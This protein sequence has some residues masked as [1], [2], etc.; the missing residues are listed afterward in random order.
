MIVTKNM[1]L[2]D[3]VCTTDPSHTKHV[4]QRG[5]FTAI[6]AM[7]QVQNATNIF[8]P[9]GQGWG[10]DFVEM[11]TDDC[12]VVKCTL[13]H[14]K[15]EYT[16]V[17]YGQKKLTTGKGPDEDA[18]KKAGTDAL[19][20]CLSYLGFN[21][22]VFLGKFDD[23]KYVSAMKA[24]HDP[25]SKEFNEWSKQATIDLGNLKNEE[26]LTKWLKTNKAT[27]DDALKNP[28]VKADAMAVMAQYQ[29]VKAEIVPQPNKEGVPF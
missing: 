11:F 18:F 25:V 2:W 4:A 16:V 14:T 9:A 1:E 17:Q 24:E 6:D 12:V 21:A 3:K 23:N 20:K 28:S 19:T 26:D 8:G 13:W 5:G 22:D 10:W 27:V 15:K 29:S 7:Y